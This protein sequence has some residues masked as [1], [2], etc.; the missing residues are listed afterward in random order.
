MAR[1]H[2][3]YYTGEDKYSDGNIENELLEIFDESNNNSYE[4]CINKND[5]ILKFYHLSKVRWGLLYWYDFKPNSVVIEVGGGCGALTEMLCQKCHQVITIEMSKRRAEIIYKRCKKY[6]NLDIYVSD[7]NSLP[8]KIMA[9]YAVIV[10]VLEYQGLY[11][12]GDDPYLSFLTDIQK[13]LNNDGRMLLAIENRLGIKYFAG[14]PE[15]HT[16]ETFTGIQNYKTRGKARTF[17]K[18]DLKYL[19]SR[20]GFSDAFFYYPM[21]DYRIAY[22]VFSD[23]YLPKNELGIRT[24]PYYGEYSR[25]ILFD[26]R[27]LY[28][29]LFANGVFDVFANSFLVDAGRDGNRY[30]KAIY[31][32]STF[33]RSPSN[34][35]CTK[36]LSD[37]FVLKSA[38]NEES[39]INLANCKYNSERINNRACAVLRAV[40]VTLD[41]GGIKMPI[42]KE[43]SL[44]VRLID[45][46]YHCEYRYFEELFDLYYSA[47]LESSD[48]ID[49]SHRYGPILRELYVEFTISNCFIN[50]NN[51]IIVFDLEKTMEKM[52]ASF[53]VFRAIEHLEGL[54]EMYGYKYDFERLKEKY[55]LSADLWNEYR[56]TLEKYYKEIF[57]D[58]ILEPLKKTQNYNTKIMYYNNCILSGNGV[59]MMPD[60]IYGR[61][62]YEDIYRN[63]GLEAY[64]AKYL[65]YIS[66]FFEND[67]D[68]SNVTTI[69]W[70]A[71]QCFGRNAYIF[72]HITELETVCD[73]DSSKWNID[74]GYGIK[75]ASPEIIKNIKLPFVVI[76]VLNPDIYWSIKQNLY[77][78]GKIKCANIVDVLRGMY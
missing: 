9:D 16:Q 42:V 10:G 48:V 39:K 66:R 69:A 61:K 51:E 23:D 59:E 57:E 2:L 26:E 35:V 70:G 63:R 53:M 37:G 34:R 36:I 17:S 25:S 15:D 58:E 24:V 47:L 22:E 52:P 56:G 38:V 67:Q 43:D 3:D 5:S 28:K 60:I 45:S 46:I 31:A 12:S 14:A 18:S 64:K 72:K 11:G 7:L 20:S 41:D 19:L 54:L 44:I 65:S 77:E 40:P 27:V 8:A 13:R 50:A 75:G 71:G 49:I 74:L 68:L 29:D 6:D 55:N 30:C 33:D 21:P 4:A 1:I 78:M 62:I 76:M 32:K 73:I